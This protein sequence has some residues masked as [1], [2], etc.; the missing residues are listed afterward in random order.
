MNKLK[1]DRLLYLVTDSRLCGDRSLEEV[2]ELAILG[3]VDLVQL[4]EKNTTKEEFLCI[5]RSLKTICDSYEIPLIIN[6]CIDVAIAI[7]ASGLHLGQS[8]L[9]YDVVR[10]RFGSEKIIGLSVNTL[11]QAKEAEDLDVDY[12]GVGPIFP[13]KTKL[14][15]GKLWGIDELKT[16]RKISNHTLIGIGGISQHNLDE[17]IKIGFNG[18]AIVSAICAAEDPKES[19]RR[20]SGMIK[21]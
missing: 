4:R 20:L 17:I 10:E 6:D 12:L 1:Q 5:G 9:P 13:T 18:V 8:D 2:V 3:G 19:A 21:V 16:L 14:D 15:A 7:D 11:E